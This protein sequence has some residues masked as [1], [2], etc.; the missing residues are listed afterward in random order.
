MPNVGVLLG[1][2]HIINSN[3]NGESIVYVDDYSYTLRTQ[4]PSLERIRNATELA[5]G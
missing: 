1:L 5:Q 4:K 3:E 2:F